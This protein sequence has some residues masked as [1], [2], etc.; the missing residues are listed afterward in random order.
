MIRPYKRSDKKYL[1]EILRLNT[2]TYFDPKEVHDFEEYLLLHDNT[3][4]TIECDHKIVGGIGYYMEESHKIGRITWIF[5]HPN[6]SGIGLGKKA[7]LHCLTILKSN[8]VLEKLVVMTSQLA[9][10]F[11]EKFDFQLEKTEKNYWGQGLDLYVM[12]QHLRN[13]N[14]N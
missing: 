9:H 4:F 10:K 2:P 13:K 12:T 8:P 5:F 11:F 7:I 1:V 14:T 6:Y 3:Y